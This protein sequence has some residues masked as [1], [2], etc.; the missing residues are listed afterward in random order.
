MKQESFPGW[1]NP[2]AIEI[3]ESDG[4]KK[5]LIGGRTYF[6]WPSADEASQRIAI[7][8]LHESKLA[9]MS[10]QVTA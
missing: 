6:S 8:Q 3:T 2:H 4:L 10:L 5:V 9:S 7:V 1:D